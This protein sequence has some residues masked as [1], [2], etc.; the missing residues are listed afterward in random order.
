[1]PT[2]GVTWP[3]ISNGLLGVARASPRRPR[4]PTPQ[5]QPT[6]QQQTPPQPLNK[7]PTNT[8]PV[9]NPTPASPP[10]TSSSAA[11][12]TTP[13]NLANPT[14]GLANPAPSPSSPPV[15]SITGN[16]PAHIHVGA[17]YSDLGATISG[18][19]A[20]KNL[21]IKTYLNGALVSNIVLDTTGVAT[22][23]IDYVAT[24]QNGLAATSTRTVIIEPAPDQT[25]IT[26][27]LPIIVATSTPPI[28]IATSTNATSSAQQ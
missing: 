4:N 10:P 11:S 23:T 15:I 17:S 2:V 7:A 26:L 19:T 1:L 9:Q 6:L 3:T 12:S 27:P 20:D 28:T 21:G 16:N 18:P 24:D 22:D 14:P 8:P 13:S 5:Q 25:Q